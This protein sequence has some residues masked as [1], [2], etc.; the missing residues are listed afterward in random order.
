MDG[1]ASLYNNS[2]DDATGSGRFRH[3]A[4]NKEL[5]KLEQPLP[6]WTFPPGQTYGYSTGH[7]GSYFNF[8]A[9]KLQGDDIWNCNAYLR[10]EVKQ[11]SKKEDWLAED[12]NTFDHR[13]NR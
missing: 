3:T 4:L 8:F 13:D 7:W 5:D 1:Y 11:G 12:N 10:I 9:G 6:S 2:D